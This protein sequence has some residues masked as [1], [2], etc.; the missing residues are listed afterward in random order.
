MAS[1]LQAL[2]SQSSGVAL[3]DEELSFVNNNEEEINN[4]DIE[5]KNSNGF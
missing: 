3:D 4:E 1:D 5:K 2:V